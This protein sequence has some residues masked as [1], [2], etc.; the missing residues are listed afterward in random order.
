MKFTDGYWLPR[1]GCTARYAAEVIGVRT[2]HH[3]G[4]VRHG[5]EFAL[6]GASDVAGVG[7]RGFSGPG[8][9]S[10]TLRCATMR[11]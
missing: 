6:P 10:V 1:P 3:A 4:S 5:P 2:T 7:V 11:R 8:R 9:N